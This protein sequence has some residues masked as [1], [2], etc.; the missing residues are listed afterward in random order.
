MRTA[1]ALAALV[2]A[3]P[4][5]A[6][7]QQVDFDIRPT[8]D[9]IDEA[10]RSDHRPLCVGEAAQACVR[11]IP[12]AGPVDVSLC[13]ER[14]TRYWAARMND[15]LEEMREKAQELDEDFA[16]TEMAEKVPFKLT[17]DLQLMQDAWKAW[18]EK[19]CAFEA[20]LHRGTPEAS[21]SAAWCMVRTTG[22]QALFLERSVRQ[23]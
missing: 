1:L 13:M 18:R 23:D 3:A 20:M 21:M 12:D 16:R 15:A 2:L 4:A 17:E 11:G 6:P 22:R 8:L 19:R 14:E 5:P 7:A 10:M 9:C